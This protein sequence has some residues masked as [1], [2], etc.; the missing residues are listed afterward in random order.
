MSAIVQLSFEAHKFWPCSQQIV[1]WE[2]KSPLKLVLRLSQCELEIEA[3][4]TAWWW[5]TG[6]TSSSTQTPLKEAGHSLLL[7]TWTIEI[8]KQFS[9]FLNCLTFWNVSGLAITLNINLTFKI[10]LCKC[11]YWSGLICDFQSM[12]K[13][14]DKLIITIYKK[15]VREHSSHDSCKWPFVKNNRSI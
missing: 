12:I 10:S 14:V 3:V 9:S 6:K 11:H 13:L 4:V 1:K 7:L 2:L 15:E 8:L 5:A